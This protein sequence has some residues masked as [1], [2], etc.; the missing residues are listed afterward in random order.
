MTTAR[1]HPP[2]HKLNSEIVLHACYTTEL[3]H[4]DRRNQQV[5]G[6]TPMARGQRLK[7]AGQPTY[8][9]TFT[10]ALSAHEKIVSGVDVAPAQVSVSRDSELHRSH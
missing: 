2:L 7:R 8:D 3:G 10:D 6:G 4:P 9:K 5:E 1:G